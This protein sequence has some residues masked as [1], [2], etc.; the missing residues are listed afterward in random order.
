MGKVV[1]P[2]V[3]II[4]YLFLMD[5]TGAVSLLAWNLLGFMHI[6]NIFFTTACVIS[7]GDMS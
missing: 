3:S 5:G 1:F 7:E 6:R 4:I 2:V